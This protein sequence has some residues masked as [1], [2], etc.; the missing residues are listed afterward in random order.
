MEKRNGTWNQKT[1]NSFFTFY[2]KSSGKPFKLSYS[3]SSSINLLE[4]KKLNI[5]KFW[6]T[7][8]GLGFDIYYLICSLSS[9]AFSKYFIDFYLFSFQDAMTK[10]IWM[11]QRKPDMYWILN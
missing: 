1:H 7:H 6:S 5:Q 10:Q 8:L 11:P 2:F 4:K 9:L 3:E